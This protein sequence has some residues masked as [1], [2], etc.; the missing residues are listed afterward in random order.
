MN[1]VFEALKTFFE[2]ILIDW[3]QPDGLTTVESVGFYI[4]AAIGLIFTLC[5]TYQFFYVFIAF[6]FRPRKYPDCKQDKRYAVL[7]AARDA[8]E[9]TL[10]EVKCSIGARE[11]LGRPTTTAI[12]NKENFMK[13]L[14]DGRK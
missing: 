12:E 4:T 11:A 9:L 6:V 8:D 13:Y 14:A 10:I 1:K 5:Y 2:W 7:T 3:I